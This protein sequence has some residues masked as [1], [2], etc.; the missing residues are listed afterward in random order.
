MHMIMENFRRFVDEDE[1]NDKVF[2]LKEGKVEKQTNLSLLI[3]ERDKGQINTL[4]LIELLNE[5][6]EY[7]F[8]QLIKEEAEV[9]DKD[10]SALGYARK[11]GVKKAA[12]FI[13]RKKLFTLF[14]KKMTSYVRALGGQEKKTEVPIQKLFAQAKAALKAGNKKQALK[15]LGTAGFKAAL[16]PVRILFK[17]IKA[18]LKGVLWLVKKLGKYMRNPVARVIMIGLLCLC[19]FQVV[20]ITGAVVVGAKIANQATALIT[21]KTAIGHGV[22]K[23]AAAGVG[24]VKKALT[25]D[26]FDVA[27]VLSSMNADELGAAIIKIA[28]EIEGQPIASSVEDVE[29]QYEG[30]DGELI[31]GGETTITY[32]DKA[33]G[34]QLDALGVMKLALAKAEAGE[35]LETA[36]VGEETAAAIRA[37]ADS[38]VAHCEWDPAACEG[39]GEYAATIK[40]V[41][42]GT[43]DSELTDIMHQ[44]GDEIMQVQQSVSKVS[45][46]TVVTGGEAGLE[47]IGADYGFHGT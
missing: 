25:E 22:G 43:V 8:N 19:M 10:L 2:I 38:A 42:G 11:H 20:T 21:G 39:A 5:S 40:E 13:F 32:A 14:Y 36:E 9:A 46:D 16:K 6:T 33:L 31:Q 3:E 27:D 1:Q 4:E 12:K 15:L 44:Q 45:G 47:K 7:E 28:S 41:W 30:P 29:L 17:A 23:A 34:A 26:V 37:S 18:V 24:A 35:T